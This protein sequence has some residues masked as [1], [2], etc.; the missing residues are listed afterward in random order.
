[1]QE[2][3]CTACGRSVAEGH[4]Q[5][6][7][8]VASGRCPFCDEVYVA[9]DQVET[10]DKTASAATNKRLGLREVSLESDILMPAFPVGLLLGL[11]RFFGS[12]QGVNPVLGLIALVAF[13]LSHPGPG[14][15]TVGVWVAYW[16]MIITVA[17]A[18]IVTGHT[19][20]DWF[21]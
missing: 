6:K 2:L 9:K 3:T 1:M 7:S 11:A 16:A 4:A 17:L 13:F 18:T 10:K 14:P 15:R 19:V 12:S 20:R 8:A 5:W 21:F